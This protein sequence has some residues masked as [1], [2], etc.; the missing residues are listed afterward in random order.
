MAK[1][2]GTIGGVFTAQT[3]LSQYDQL[4][5]NGEIISTQVLF[6]PDI[7]RNIVNTYGEEPLENIV[8][9]D[10]DKENA[11]NLLEY[12][13]TTPLYIILN[14]D[15]E[16]ISL[17]TYGAQTCQSNNV[18]TKLSLLSSYWIDAQHKGEQIT[19][20]GKDRYYCQKIEYGQTVGYENTNLIYPGELVGN[21]GSTAMAA[22][23]SIKNIYS[24]YEY[25]YDVFGRFVF[26]KK[27]TSKYYTIGYPTIDSTDGLTISLPKKENVTSAWLF[28]NLKT[29]T[30]LSSNPAIS[31]VKNDFTVWGQRK[32]TAGTLPIHMRVAIQK[33]PVQYIPSYSTSQNPLVYKDIDWR[34]IIYQMALD[35]NQNKGNKT[36][37]EW[38][39]IVKEKN[40]NLYP[41]GITGYEDYY[42]DMLAF[43]RKMYDGNKPVSYVQTVYNNTYKNAGKLY[44]GYSDIDIELNELNENNISNIYVKKSDVSPQERSRYIDIIDVSTLFADQENIYKKVNGNYIDV[45]KEALA[46][47]AVYCKIGDNDY[48]SPLTLAIKKVQ[49]GN[50]D[51]AFLEKLRRDSDI[52][53]IKMESIRKNTLSMNLSN[54][55]NNW[56][57]VVSL[58]KGNSYSVINSIQFQDETIDDKTVIQSFDFLSRLKD[59]EQSG[60]IKKINGE[61][62]SE[63][64]S[65]IVIW[66][67]NST[68][69]TDNTRIDYYLDNNN[70][71]QFLALNVVTSYKDLYFQTADGQYEQVL[72]KLA[73]DKSALYYK[74]GNDYVHIINKIKSN[75]TQSQELVL[76]RAQYSLIR[77]NDTCYTGASFSSPVYNWV[78][79]IIS[80]QETPVMYYYQIS[81]WEENSNW[82]STIIQ[83]PWTRL[84]WIELIE[85][86]DGKWYSEYSKEKIGKRQKA[87]NDSN[88][89][90]L[91]YPDTPGI[92]FTRQDYAT[93]ETLTNTSGTFTNLPEV[94]NDYFVISN[95]GKSVQDAMDELLYKHTFCAET[96]ST[97][98]LPVYSI[99]P[100]EI[101][102]IQ[103]ENMTGIDELYAVNSLSFSLGSGGLM[104][105]NLTK[106][107]TEG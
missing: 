25:F 65:T 78:G 103:D 33:K 24:N 18:I 49:D 45:V 83:E 94:Y 51:I 85:P 37:A 28:E 100:N 44:W 70:Q 6:L 2:N 60:T 84:F 14:E 95:Q 82:N 23:D 101:I 36:Q 21:V 71:Y 50:E 106:L 3:S 64:E 77:A 39:S 13:G 93:S 55:N 34:E 68:K 30:S 47:Q 20:G 81:P 96:V 27:P 58:K 19:F 4:N 86:Q 74:A 105:L 15:G 7:I 75:Q 59:A 26:Q 5:E 42:I 38:R 97:Q 57:I 9:K 31:E 69:S 41:D 62:Y 98:A 11:S 17:T 67:V 104:S 29:Q 53:Q 35:E 40:G 43:W 12:Q 76:R 88:T 8:I 99:Q 80:Y 89:T 22:L 61:N 54:F 66:S 56:P 10:L 102:Q 79:E 32:T 72:A 63:T 91:I 48:Y 52:L 73:L 87:L 46:Q 16:L 1:L 90:A 107:F 92:N